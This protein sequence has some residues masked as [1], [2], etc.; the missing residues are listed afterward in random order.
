MSARPSLGTRGRRR[1]S[2]C[3]LFLIDRRVTSAD[4]HCQSKP[5]GPGSQLE[6]PPEDFFAFILNDSFSWMGLDGERRGAASQLRTL[7]LCSASSGPCAS[8]HCRPRSTAGSHG[9]AL[10]SPPMRGLPVRTLPNF[11]DDDLFHR[12]HRYAS[13][14][15]SKS[16]SSPPPEARSKGPDLGARVEAARS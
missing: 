5:E 14:F 16:G 4:D 3:K 7:F 13:P 11:P 10:S 9:G 2:L 15:G 1:S 8:A 12:N 6:G